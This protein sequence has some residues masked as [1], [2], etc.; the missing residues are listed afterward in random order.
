MR[1]QIVF[2]KNSGYINFLAKVLIILTSKKIKH[3]EE[4]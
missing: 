3:F 4:I 1:E 2:G